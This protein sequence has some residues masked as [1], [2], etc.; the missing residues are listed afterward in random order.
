M[1]AAAQRT[2]LAR[3]SLVMI[4]SAGGLPVAVKAKRYKNSFRG[5]SKRRLYFSELGA[6]RERPSVSGPCCCECGTEEKSG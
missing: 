3:L 5:L 2:I 6:I 4:R 1:E